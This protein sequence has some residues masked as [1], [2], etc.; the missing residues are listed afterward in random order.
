MI[1][2]GRLDEALALVEETLAHEVSEMASAHLTLLKAEL[3]LQRGEHTA[4]EAAL[5]AARE[6]GVDA[7]SAEFAGTA[8][9]I[10]AELATDQGRIDD[11]RAAVAEGLERLSD[12]WRLIAGLAAAGI[13][14]EA[15]APE[16]SPAAVAGLLERLDQLGSA[17]PVPL[18]RALILTARAEATRLGEPSPGGWR[19]AAETWEAL[20]APCRA[21]WARLREA[22]ALLAAGAGRE[23]AAD[24][25]RAAAAAARTTGALRLLRAVERLAGRARIDVGEARQDDASGLTPREREVLVHL[26]A[27]RTNRQIADAL[28]ISPR[29][30]G[31]HV[32]RI[33]A[34]LGATTRGE[35]AAAG[36]LAGVI[37]EERVEALLTRSTG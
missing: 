31:V 4:C 16:P 9:L 35:A 1:T 13:A 12:D 11:A 18:T 7:R 17:N 8:A 2:L 15:A 20:R 10:R 37:D 21:G 28:Y 3:M 19:E 30:A 24:P 36:R 6:L 33:L 25:L 27:G 26:A 14:A 5:A 29:T 34:K 22:E 23:A 32:S